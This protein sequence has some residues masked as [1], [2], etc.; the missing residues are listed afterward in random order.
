M[1]EERLLEEL[2]TRIRDVRQGP[3]G[4]LYLLTDESDG[5]MLRR[6]PVP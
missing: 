2:E 3:G 1:R 5:A 4:R 6:D